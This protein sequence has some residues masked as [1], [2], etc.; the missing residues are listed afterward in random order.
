[1]KAF[2]RKVFRF[3]LLLKEVKVWGWLCSSKLDFR[4]TIFRVYIGVFR[5]TNV[6]ECWEDCAVTSLHSVIVSGIRSTRVTSEGKMLI[7]MGFVHAIIDHR[8]FTR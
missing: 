5:G 3:K 1:M 6:E 4:G 8:A 2:L 7:M